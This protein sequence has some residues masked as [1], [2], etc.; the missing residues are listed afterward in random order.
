[1]VRQHEQSFLF[2]PTPKNSNDLVH[3]TVLML[4]F[5]LK[6]PLLTWNAKNIVQIDSTSFYQ[7]TKEFIPSQITIRPGILKFVQMALN[8]V[9]IDLL[10][11]ELATSLL[12]GRKYLHNNR[13]CSTNFMVKIIMLKNKVSCVTFN[14]QLYMILFYRETIL[15]TNNHRNFYAHKNKAELRKTKPCYLL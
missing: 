3:C 7:M 12:K 13:S 6:Y 11:H 4:D 10:W 9:R 14:Y 8:I 15:W 2:L 5:C 1:M